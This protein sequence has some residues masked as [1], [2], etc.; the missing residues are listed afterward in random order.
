MVR[1]SFDAS[2]FPSNTWRR[3]RGARKRRFLEDR[4]NDPKVRWFELMLGRY[5]WSTL[6]LS[7]RH[8]IGL[9]RY[10]LLAETGTKTGTVDR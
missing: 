4:R 2:C 10:P 8:K 9:V 6:P 1:T 5:R 3:L 7:R